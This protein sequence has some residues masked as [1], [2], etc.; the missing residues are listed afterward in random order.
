[1]SILSRLPAAALL[2]ASPAFAANTLTGDWGG[3]RSKLDAEGI[4]LTADYVSETMSNVH[5]GQERGTRYA[6]QVRL[7]AR[8]DLAKLLGSPD[9]GVVQF[10]VNDRRGRS[11]SA[12]LVGNR[13]PAQEVY[14][15]LYTRI[16]E[17]SYE[18]TL[19]SPAFDVKAGYMAMGNDFGGMAILTDFVNAAFCAHPLSLS[20]GSGW[21]NYPSAHWGSEFKYRINA[22]WRVQTAVFQ[23]NPVTNSRSRYALR[24]STTGTTGAILPVEL[25]YDLHASLPGQYKAGWYYDTSNTARIDGSGKASNRHGAYLLA[26]QMVWRNPSNDLQNLHVFGQA[27]SADAATSPFR[28]WYSAGLVLNAPFASRPRDNLGFAW[29]R[30]VVNP[31]TRAN[32]E[33]AASAE[34]AEAIDNLAGGEQVAELSYGAQLTDW[35]LVRPDVQYIAEPGAFYGEQTANTWLAGVQLKVTF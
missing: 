29:G 25:V 8:F 23:V 17:L 10:T 16:S 32:Q 13:L 5:G 18:R 35:L 12:D 30:A 21:T 31:R 15:G 1:M 9:A 33:A 26:D 14:G 3:E 19:F 22:D 28:H 24:L 4:H 2:L 11:T 7:G 27:T 6:Q 20:G 34:N